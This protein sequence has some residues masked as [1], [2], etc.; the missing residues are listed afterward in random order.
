MRGR[1]DQFINEGNVFA[2]LD[3]YTV[4]S[5]PMTRQ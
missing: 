3:Q 2:G 1:A 5:L 4:P